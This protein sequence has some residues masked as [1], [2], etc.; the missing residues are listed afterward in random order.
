M[1]FPEQMIFKIT[2]QQRDEIEYMAEY[3]RVSVSDLCRL[4]LYLLYE[5]FAPG[6]NNDAFYKEMSQLRTRD[7]IEF[8]SG[9]DGQH[10]KQ[11]FLSRAMNMKMLDRWLQ[12]AESGEA[13]PTQLLEDFEYRI[14]MPPEYPQREKILELEKQFKARLKKK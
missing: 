1:K 5:R 12:R 8:M 2:E 7:S 6:Q 11:S 4:S 9:P 13:D 14:F 10:L 3:Y